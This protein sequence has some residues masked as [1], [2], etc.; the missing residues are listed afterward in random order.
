MNKAEWESAQKHMAR[1]IKE[2]VRKALA[3]D[4]SVPRIRRGEMSGAGEVLLDGESTPRPV[5]SLC[6]AYAGGERVAVIV[7][8]TNLYVIGKL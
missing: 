4:P 8:E 7:C 5:S 2:H 3:S 6:T 1:L